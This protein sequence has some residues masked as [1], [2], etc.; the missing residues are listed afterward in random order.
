LEVNLFYDA[1]C[2]MKIECEDTLSVNL[3]KGIMG[4]L[5]EKVVKV[6]ELCSVITKY[7][8]E[9]LNILY[10]QRMEGYEIIS[11]DINIAGTI[12]YFECFDSYKDKTALIA[13]SLEDKP[14]DL[15][16]MEAANPDYDE[17]D[18]TYFGEYDKTGLIE[19]LHVSDTND[20]P[21]SLLQLKE[22]VDKALC[23]Y[24]SIEE[25]S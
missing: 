1:K 8:F 25:D 5:E 11:V 18:Q 17:Y 12:K 24:D 13:V 14:V 19:W 4:M 3:C 10:I 20:L 23:E 16:I 9:M 7:E 6:K 21:K 15:E 22:K 2:Q